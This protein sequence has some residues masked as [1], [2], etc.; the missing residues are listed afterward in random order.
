MGKNR[1]VLNTKE[2]GV[3]I[4]LLEDECSPV[5]TAACYLFQHRLNHTS[6]VDVHL[7]EENKKRPLFV[8]LF[9]KENNQFSGEFYDCF[10]YL[11]PYYEEVQ[12][13]IRKHY[14]L[15]NM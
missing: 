14:G 5:V 1:I 7:Q 9:D 11:M 3:H 12:L 2:L 13:T 4:H 6:T 10:E 8:L 15:S